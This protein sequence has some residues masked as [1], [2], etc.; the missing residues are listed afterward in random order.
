MSMCFVNF[1][2]IN[3]FIEK[4]NEENQ[5]VR[6]IKILLFQDQKELS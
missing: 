5:A 2:N 6:T 4:Q 3:F 1:K